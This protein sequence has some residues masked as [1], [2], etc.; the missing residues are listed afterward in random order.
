MDRDQARMS[1]WLNRVAGVGRKEANMITAALHEKCGKI[2][3]V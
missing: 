2:L 1:E 3:T